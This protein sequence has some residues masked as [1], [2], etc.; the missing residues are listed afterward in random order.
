MISST[1]CVT[2]YTGGGLGRVTLCLICIPRLYWG[3]SMQDSD[4]GAFLGGHT[5]ILVFVAPRCPFCA[6]Y[7]APGFLCP[8]ELLGCGCCQMFHSDMCTL[9]TWG[10]LLRGGKG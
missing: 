5:I 6:V 7:H 2:K 3:C 8:G 10:L 9:R 4:N 1:V